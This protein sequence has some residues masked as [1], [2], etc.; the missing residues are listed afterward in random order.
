MRV[1]GKMISSMVRVL[2][3]GR[4]VVVM[5]VNTHLERRKALGSMSGL[6]AQFMKDSGLIIELV[7]RGYICGRMGGSITEHG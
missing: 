2:R 7:E 5:K 3:F 6:M 1:F 4:K